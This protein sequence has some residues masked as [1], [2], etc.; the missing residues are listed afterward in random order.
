[1]L[2]NAGPDCGSGFRLGAG[3]VSI[4]LEARRLLYAP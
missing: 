1:M 2:L 4:M 3:P